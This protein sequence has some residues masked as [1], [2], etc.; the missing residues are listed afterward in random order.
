VRQGR[1]MGPPKQMS[2]QLARVG[3][4]PAS[5][6]PRACGDT[7]LFLSV[8]LFGFVSFMIALATLTVPVPT[9]STPRRRAPP[10]AGPHPA[11]EMGDPEVDPAL[12]ASQVHPKWLQAPVLLVPS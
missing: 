8:F 1:R 5:Q 2:R 9:P 11:V 10:P 4:T 6:A 7:T 12:A 3:W